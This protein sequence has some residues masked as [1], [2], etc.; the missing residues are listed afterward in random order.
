MEAA[1]LVSFSTGST[2]IVSMLRHPQIL[3]LVPQKGA[4]KLIS[5]ITLKYKVLFISF[6]FQSE[7][8]GVGLKTEMG[9]EGKNVIYLRKIDGSIVNNIKNNSYERQSKCNDE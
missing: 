9:F 7:F 1:K 5:E 4:P 6:V 8:R 2:L 3:P